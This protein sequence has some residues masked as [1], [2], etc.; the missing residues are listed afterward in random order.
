LRKF[1]KFPFVELGRVEILG[2]Y[3]Y[4]WDDKIILVLEIGC[5]D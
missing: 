2:I 4:R 5:K 1:I 3:R